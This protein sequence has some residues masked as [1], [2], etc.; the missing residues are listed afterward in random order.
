MYRE[1]SMRRDCV[2]SFAFETPGIR[3]A[4]TNDPKGLRCGQM[5]DGL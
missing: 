3:S 4:Y 5:L 1:L 2:D